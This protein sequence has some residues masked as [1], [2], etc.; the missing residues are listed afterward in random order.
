MEIYE[1]T[2]KVVQ[3]PFSFSSYK[4]LNFREEKYD[5]RIDFIQRRP[6]QEYVQD[7]GFDDQGRPIEVIRWRARKLLQDGLRKHESQSINQAV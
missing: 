2:K 4:N 5:K 3:V 6:K 1:K 7:R